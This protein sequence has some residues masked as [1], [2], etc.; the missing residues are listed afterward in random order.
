MRLD[1]MP[2]R[3][4]TIETELSSKHTR[5]YNSRQLSC[6]LP[7]VARMSPSDAK[8]VEASALRF[9]DCTAADSPDFDGR[10]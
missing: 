9:K 8:K 1:Q 3:K 7:R 5:S 10:H 4:S 6:V 2:C